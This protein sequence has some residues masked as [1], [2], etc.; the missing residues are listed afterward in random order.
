MSLPLELVQ[1]IIH[2]LLFSAPPRSST[3]ERPG[4]T[5]KPTWGTINVL[6]LTSQSYRAVVLEAWFRTL[7]IESPVDLLFLRD[8]GWFPNLGSKWARHLHC[9]RSFRN[10]HYAWNLSSFLRVSSIRLDWL[11]LTLTSSFIPPDAGLDTLPFLHLASTVEHFDLRGHTSP[12][13]ETIQCIANTPGFGCL[14]TLKMVRDTVWCEL[15]QLCRLVRFE[16]RPTGVVYEGGLG[17][18]IDYA[19]VLAPFEYLEEVVIIIPSHG[20]G[21]TTWGSNADSDSGPNADTNPQTTTTSN[22][23]VNPNLWSGECDTCMVMMYCDDVFLDEGEEEEEEDERFEDYEDVATDMASQLNSSLEGIEDDPIT[24]RVDRCNL[25]LGL[26]D[27]HSSNLVNF[28]PSFK[29]HKDA[30]SLA[31]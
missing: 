20:F 16:D 14:K 12:K 19:H 3:P 8:S 18:P 29:R 17:L 6:S 22:P 30:E 21:N 2:L 9:V 4:C 23:K 31:Q 24:C 13:P 1:E 10:T 15:C 27:Y 11:S 25:S 7:F 26:E 28:L 5:A